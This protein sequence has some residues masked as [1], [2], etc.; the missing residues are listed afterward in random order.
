M[1]SVQCSWMLMHAVLASLGVSVG[2]VQSDYEVRLNEQA[3]SLL[4]VAQGDGRAVPLD[5]VVENVRAFAERPDAVVRIE[6]FEDEGDPG[7]NGT[8]F[9]TR[10][11][12][13]TESSATGA[14]DCRASDGKVV[15]L[16]RRGS[17]DKSLPPIITEAQALEIARQFLFQKCPEFAARQWALD[18][19]WTHDNGS[20]YEF[21]WTE[22]LNEHG[23]RAVYDLR[24][25]VEK[26]TGKILSYQFPPD[27]VVGPLVPG[28]TLEQAKTL[29][30]EF[31]AYDPAVIPFEPCFPQLIEDENGIQ[32][33]W[34]V[35]H[36]VVPQE[37]A[38][39]LD[40]V[41]S[42][43]ALAGNTIIPPDFPFGFP[44]EEPSGKEP[45]RA[46][47]RKKRKALVS[48]LIQRAGPGEP[49]ARVSIAE[50]P[51]LAGTV[52]P[53][54]RGN[55]V[56]L[57]AE[58]LRPLGVRVYTTPKG[59]LLRAAGRRVRGS[60]CGAEF[61]EHGWWVPL[62]PVAQAFDW[63][64]EWKPKERQAILRPPQAGPQ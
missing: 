11:D 52:M 32:T 58:L 29:A 21:N 18:Y 5:V 7:F 48:K 43:E 15:L 34:W 39:A 54:V 9:R 51:D 12:E 45:W 50:G 60:E 44:T 28:I 3:R 41:V 36:Q 19:P 26:S 46:P 33:L 53:V 23:T 16:I 1:L 37:G 8:H 64:L 24:V 30:A 2:Q 4:Q 20:E 62:K 55:R 25:A 49:Q 57:R 10:I 40:R 38:R 56:W 63:S 13:G 31:A 42:V 22:V 59:L 14:Y 27:R 17:P 47:L 6:H 35:L 61:R